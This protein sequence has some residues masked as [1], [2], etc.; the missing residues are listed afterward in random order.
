MNRPIAIL[1]AAGLALGL[2]AA[3][4]AQQLQLNWLDTP[5]PGDALTR[6]LEDEAVRMAK[7][8]YAD[9]PHS[10]AFDY[11]YPAASEEYRAMGANG[12]LLL[13]AV[14]K[15]AKELPI[16][17]VV[18]R[19]GLKEV[20]LQPIA[21]R[22]SM[23]PPTS[24]LAKAIGLNREDAFFLLPGVLPGKTADLV[25]VFAV[26]GRQFKA[27]TLSLAPPEVSKIFVKPPVGQ[28]DPAV[29]TAVLA[30][31]YPNLVKP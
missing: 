12:V 21:S 11:V 31:E 24:P 18:L 28:P 25:I 3:A 19:F 9:H 15:D 27:G 20:V 14:A 10:A 29:L 8:D 7:V 22:Q 1:L 30:R 6:R 23:V 13:A 17:Q 16:K 26:P 4:H 2:A 5:P